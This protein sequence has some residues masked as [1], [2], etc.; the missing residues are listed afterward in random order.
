MRKTIL[1]LAFALLGLAAPVSA[2]AAPVFN[3]E[4]HHNQT[5]F[6]PGGTPAGPPS[7]STTTQGAP[8]STNEVQ[9]VERPIATSGSFRL[10]FEGDTT[11]NIPLDS[12][13]VAVRA[14]LQALPSI[15]AGNVKVL[16]NVLTYGSTEVVDGYTVTF[17]GALAGVDV[18]QLS[19]SEGS[20]G[21]EVDSEYWI[22]LANV[23]PDPTSGP[24]T[25]T[26]P[27]PNGLTRLSVETSSGETPPFIPWSCPGSP[28][29]HVVTCTTTGVIG[30]HEFN[31]ELKVRVAVAA[32]EG[33]LRTASAKVTGGGAAEAIAK[34]PTPISST[35]APFGIVAPTFLPDFFGADGLTPEREAGAHPVLFTVPFDFNSV[36]DPGSYLGPDEKRELGSIRNLHVDTPPGFIGN[37]SAVGEC[38]QQA[39]E[40]SACP[41]S[42]QLGRIEVQ[43]HPPISST[44]DSDY[45][46]FNRPVY[47][48]EHPRGAISDLA[49]VIGGNPVHI[50]AFLDPANHYAITTHVP[51][52]NES[53]PPLDQKLT[54]W[55]VPADHTHDAERCDAGPFS[56]IV[57]A[58]ECST[59]SES[60]PFLSLPSQCEA[61]NVMRLHH[62]NSWQEPGVY[63]QE[64]DYTLP[65]KMTHCERPRFEPTVEIE[66]T[67]KQANTPTGLDVHIK[68]AQNE[69]PN[70]LATP[71][72]QRITV[73]LPQG[74]SFSP[75]FSDGLQSCTLAQM[76][77][78]N[79]QEV[80]C[81]PASRIGEVELSS[82]LLPKRLEGSMYL[83]AQGDNPFGSTFALLLVLHDTEE[84]GVLVKIPGRIDVDEE[85]GKITTVFQNTPQF[86]FDDLTLKF[87]SGPR[88]PLVSPP[89]CGTHVIGVE[90]ASYA[91]PQEALNRSNDYQ[92]NEGPNGTPCPPESSKRPFHP[93]FTGGTLNP[94][95]GHFS[96]FL[97]RMQRT[98][99]EQELSQVS[100]I[101]PPG[102]VAKLAGT[103][104]CP[105]QAINSISTQ[106]GT[107]AAEAAH[108]ACPA[109][110][111]FGSIS[112]GLGAGPGPNYFPGKAYLAGPYKGAP[113]SLAVVAPGIA[114][115]FDLGNVVVRTA[116]YVDPV[117]SQ[118]KAVSDPFPTKLHGVILRVRDVRLRLDKAETTINPTSCAKMALGGQITG[119]GGD[120][121]S[122]ADDSLFDTQA[123]FQV[124]SCGDLAF[125]PH[126]DLHLFGATHRGS[127]P[128]FRATV[129][130]PPGG[131]NTAAASVALPHSEFLDQ[132][133]IQTVCTRVQFAA[134]SCPAG[135]IYGT[136]SAKTPLLDETLSGPIYLRSSSNPLPDIV[137]TFRGGRI[138]AN[139]IGRVDSVNGGIRNTFDF[140]PDVPVTEATFSFFGGNKGLLVNS[141]DICKGT[142]K[143]TA[144]FK[145]H[146]GAALTFRPPL[147]S[148]CA[149]AK[150]HKKQKRHK[151][152]R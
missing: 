98:D 45:H 110:S 48:M 77:L 71:P 54:L 115:P 127:H 132:G 131:A 81:P 111:E 12:S 80:Q 59:D 145:A 87:R 14:A 19:A 136:V 47:N 21:L 61:D 94:V 32:P 148:A 102:L 28:G 79:N 93:D 63:G 105:D 39:L 104:L 26:L 27:L 35:P 118:V 141:R 126:L 11:A 2:S 52:I 97:F 70:A 57:T 38:P 16:A 117:T 36:D 109:S 151:R 37:P 6:P 128:K 33:A 144:I 67:G 90:V 5:N 60:R 24:I 82:P 4:L 55:G 75:S 25:V 84:R 103:S 15:G 44:L 122:T 1:T 8:P 116:L 99:D 135:S 86:P 120:L 51:D 91:R 96:T 46:T 129:K 143:A 112:A 74:M 121:N 9:Q 101:L 69:N 66:P 68:I 23:G 13:G 152:Q 62:Y 137:A 22:N 73:T 133:H 65:G 149:K 139:L 124:G 43:T 147:K 123:P 49:F 42:S 89:F 78:G 58:E 17:T 10:T 106:L 130:F 150:K 20:P 125:K 34:E 29:D 134:N 142:P 76:Q 85:T 83:A 92:I 31:R 41:P 107:G 88:A 140:V 56:N 7:V 53:L 18:P 64:I 50:R 72:V 100:A 138:D 40:L 95:A 114:G 30:R 146:N 119:V 108:P 113:L 3:L